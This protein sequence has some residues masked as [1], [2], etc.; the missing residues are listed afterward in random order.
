MPKIYVE[1]QYQNGRCAY[2]GAGLP[3]PKN[4]LDIL[5][6]PDKWG[7]MVTAVM[8]GVK[9]GRVR[10]IRVLVG[11][12]DEQSWDKMAGLV[13]INFEPD[14]KPGLAQRIQLGLSDRDKT[15]M[16]WVSREQPPSPRPELDRPPVQTDHD[17]SGISGDPDALPAYQPD[18]GPAVPGPGAD[19]ADSGG[20]AG[21]APTP[22]H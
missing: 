19:G 20:A 5:P 8:S 2:S 1:L 10:R 18:A 17:P 16:K 22:G 13:S 14:R 11:D 9:P 12:E 6:G 15:F 21:A 4:V 7:P 3:P